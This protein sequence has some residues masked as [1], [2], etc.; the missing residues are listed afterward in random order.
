MHLFLPPAIKK[1]VIQPVHTHT[2]THTKVI[3]PVHTH[4]YKLHSQHIV[5]EAVR[6]GVRL[7]L[8]SSPP[9]SLYL[10]S[11]KAKERDSYVVR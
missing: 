4:T 7:S 5:G 10:P 9:S 2:H 1:K 3:Q 11:S 6:E 8:P